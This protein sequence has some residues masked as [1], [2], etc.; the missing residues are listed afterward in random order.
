MELE[1]LKPHEFD[2][3]IANGT[4]RLAFVGMSNAGK[5]YRSRMLHK[6]A[7]FLWYQV[8]EQI[9]KDLDFKA[10]EDISTWMGLPGSEGYAGREK[11]YLE[12]ENKYTRHASMQTKGRNL[13]FDTTGSVPHLKQK[14][15]D[16]LHANCLVVH[17]DIGGTS[18]EAMI[19]KFFSDPK[20]V[21]WTTFF[22]RR[23]GETT[24]DALRR[25]YPGLLEARL[26]EYRTLA[27]VNVPAFDVRNKSAEETLAIIRSHL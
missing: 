8:D 26:I 10:I 23:S 11:K 5:T 18:I 17:L 22:N 25:C 2:A 19:E 24:E 20:P 1:K 13:V 6:E 15:R 27:H 12:L 14:T 9:Q 7:D 4:F 3:H 21:V 16:I